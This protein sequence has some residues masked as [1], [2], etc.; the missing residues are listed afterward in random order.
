MVYSFFAPRKNRP[1][2]EPCQSHAEERQRNDWKPVNS[3]YTI[4]S[5]WLF[6][7]DKTRIE[8]LY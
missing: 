3:I 2:P 4:A 5:R 6:D 1:T 8:C 7:D